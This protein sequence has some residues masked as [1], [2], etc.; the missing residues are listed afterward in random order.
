MNSVT[1]AMTAA[2]FI[3]VTFLVIWPYRIEAAL[4][5][6]ELSPAS[7]PVRDS[8]Q[9]VTTRHSKTGSESP[10]SWRVAAHPKFFVQEPPARFKQGA[11]GVSST[12]DQAFGYRALDETVSEAHE[13]WGSR[14]Y[15]QD[16]WFSDQWRISPLRSHSAAE[17]DAVLVP[18]SLAIR[19]IDAQVS[20]GR[21]RADAQDL[22]A[23]CTALRI[24]SAAVA[25][26]TIFVSASRSCPAGRCVARAPASLARL[27]V[28]L[29]A[30][31][32]VTSGRS[33]HR[34]LSSRR[35]PPF[36]R[37]L[38]ASR[39]CWCSIMQPPPI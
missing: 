34:M 20:G 13:L 39:I 17:A 27:F 22:L 14:W 3:A 2:T 19:D 33:L 26:L 36:C 5:K 9:S 28:C 29:L 21:L 38:A 4:R 16:L 10:A 25:K 6:L 8:P 15:N 30:M 24:Y 1:W 23:L 11:N 32:V 12:A 35:L 18:A 31:Q 7:Q 37:S